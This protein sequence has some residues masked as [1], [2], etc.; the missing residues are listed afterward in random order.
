LPFNFL[1][2]KIYGFRWTNGCAH[3]D[4]DSAGL[5]PERVFSFGRHD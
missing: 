2:L 1:V 4:L 5:E 3:A